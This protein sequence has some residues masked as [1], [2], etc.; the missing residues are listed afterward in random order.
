MRRK[1]VSAIKMYEI[2]IANDCRGTLRATVGQ[3]INCMDAHLSASFMQNAR[4]IKAV[5]RLSARN[6][7]DRAVVRILFLIFREASEGSKA[8]ASLFGGSACV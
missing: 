6:R 8:F 2:F 3:F 7:H 5:Y 1:I 4:R